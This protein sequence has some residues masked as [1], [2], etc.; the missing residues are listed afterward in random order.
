M[1]K[2]KRLF[3]I[4]EED[5]VRMFFETVLG[6]AGWEVYALGNIEDASFRIPEFNPDIIILDTCLVAPQRDEIATWKTGKAKKIGLGFIGE[7]E[8]WGSEIDAFLE[9]P[10]QPLT[11]SDKILSL[12]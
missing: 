3:C 4:I 5:M 1:S 10:L 2:A 6:D 9:K 7:K 8:L 11:L 12:L